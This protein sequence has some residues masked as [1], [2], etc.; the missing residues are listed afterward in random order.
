MRIRQRMITTGIVAIAA[1]TMAACSSSGT[2]ED[3]Q[4]GTSAATGG[5]SQSAGET[6]SGSGAAPVTIK[7]SSWHFA[8][9]G[10]GDALKALV[11]E[12]NKTHPSITVEPVSIP[13]PN[14]VSTVL[15]Q[16]GA[17]SGP[18]VINFENAPFAAAVDQG[19]FVD[20]TDDI[21]TPPGGFVELDKYASRDGHRYGAVYE[22]NSYALIINQDLLDKAG[23]Q[24]PKTYD[25]FKA[26]AA[27]LTDAAAGQ[28]G[29]AFRNTLPELSGWWADITN[30]V[31]GNG[32]H[33]AD[34]SGQP[35]IDTPEVIKAFTEYKDFY[36]NYVPQGADAA[37]YR[38]MFWE[39]K[40]AMEIDNLAVPS[41]F[42][43][44]NPQIKLTV[45]PNPFP[46]PANSAQLEF[47]SVNKASKSPEAA[48]TF[49][50]W[51]LEP[52]NQKAL[53]KAMSY[54]GVATPVD[55]D[56]ATDPDVP[57]WKPVYAETTK[58]AML[59]ELPG[60][61]ADMNQ[62]QT[63]VLQELQ[64]VLLN[65]ESPEDAAKNAQAAVAGIVKK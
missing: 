61:E 24:P 54:Q 30:W 6:D 11:D 26:A 8:E 14:Y 38:R 18:D 45:V 65:S 43:T 20:L 23:L 55:W 53:S 7:F 28:Y 17:N 57:A 13:Y 31:Y 62:I 35:T 39:G 21:K 27:K 2:S 5:T 52:D 16:L 40:V 22:T 19:L 44:S 29:F 58:S 48:I 34:D 64:K 50:N 49:I 4:P 51:L 15:T 42:K 41:I 56:P 25:E 60:S 12:F 32:G 1:V 37:T 3:N 59:Q 10:R 33:W 36:D 9:P 46:D 63:A 47:M